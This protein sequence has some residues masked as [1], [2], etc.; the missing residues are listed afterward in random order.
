M[1]A[2]QYGEGYDPA[3]LRTFRRKLIAHADSVRPAYY[4]SFSRT[5]CGSG[6]GGAGPLPACLG[7]LAVPDTGRRRLGAGG[8]AAE[9]PSADWR[10]PSPAPAPTAPRSKE[11]AG[12]RPLAR[13]PSLDY[14]VMS[15]EDWEEEP[16]GE[17]LS[18]GGGGRGS[19]LPACLQGLPCAGCLPAGAGAPGLRAAAAA[20]PSL[21]HR[22]RTAPAQDDDEGEGEEEA[23]GEGGEE[24]EGDGFV[25][26]DGYLSDDEGV[27]GSQLGSALEEG[28]GGAERDGG[29][30]A[31]AALLPGLL[32][33]WGRPPARPR[34]P[35]L[36]GV[37]T[38]PA[39]QPCCRSL[40]RPRPRPRP[41]GSGEVAGPA[42]A[43]AALQALEAGLERARRA[44]RP[45]LLVALPGVAWEPSSSLDPALLAA[46]AGEVLL[47]G[48]RP[49]LPGSA[50]APGSA[51]A[52]AAASAS[53]P[54]AGAPAAPLPCPSP[55]CLPA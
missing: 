15:D 11:V 42:N 24:E 23:G 4:G 39:A 47:P 49:A 22:P 48:V 28:R 40:S 9:L 5:R 13:D 36:G 2:R 19:S 46:L 34:S 52:A 31:G 8:C 12:R 3:Q 29:A 54:A 43:G 50:P 14:E 7:C 6:R 17:S 1:A 41:A 38:R 53:T 27:R 44:N 45:L 18:V 21:A 26:D 10:P 55:A 51:A 30:G 37:R 16:E 32:A 25:V 33:C 20:A 35:A